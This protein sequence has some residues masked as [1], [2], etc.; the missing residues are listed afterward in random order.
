MKECYRV[1][2]KVEWLQSK[3]EQKVAEYKTKQEQLLAYRAQI[4]DKVDQFFEMVVQRVQQRRDT[5]KSEY[6]VI[7]SKE[8]RRLKSK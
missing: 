7:E 1:K 5:L 2:E 6:K 8:K 3:Y 4:Y